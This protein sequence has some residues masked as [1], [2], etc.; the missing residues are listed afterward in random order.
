MRPQ[1]G[2]A[3]RL[4]ACSIRAVSDTLSTMKTA[5]K[6]TLTTFD[7]LTQ[8]VAVLTAATAVLP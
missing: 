6:S 7:S 3:S 1:A 8:D 2:R 5:A 4:R